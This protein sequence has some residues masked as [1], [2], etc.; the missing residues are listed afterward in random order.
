MNIFVSAGEASSD[1]HCAHLLHEMK[2]LV[3]DGLTAFGLGGDRLA[4]A[5]LELLMHNREFSV[6]GGPLEILSKLPKRH[7]LESMLEK[8]LFDGAKVDGAVLVDNGEINLRLAALLHFFNVPVVYFIPPK[9]WVWRHGRIETIE[10]HVDLVLS[11]LPFE[12]PIYRNWDIPFQYVGNPLIDEI[13]STLTECE[14][15][16]RLGIESARRVLTVFAGSRH[17]EVRYH[18]EPFAQAVR[19]FVRQLDS[20]EEKPLVLL[21]AAQAVNPIEL[22]QAFRARLEGSGVEVRAVKGQSHECLKAAR[23]ALVKSGTST[24]EAALLGTPMVLAYQTSR[25]SAWI[26]RHIVRYFGFVGLVNLFLA[27]SAESALGWGP[28]ESPVVPELVLEDCT[29]EKIAANLSS[30]YREGLERDTMRKQLARTRDLLLPPTDASGD[31]SPLKIA[32]KAA[33]AVFKGG[34]GHGVA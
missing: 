12:E 24:L 4:S 31:R 25:S 11:I 23:A 9:I 19:M 22:E 26:Y 16:Q 17:N 6:G 21:P 30:I 33:L 32:A 27:K 15:K 29:P 10:Q 7:R 18:V 1:I 20:G 14:A 3:G 28:R 2:K 8:R 5:G 34:G 13:D